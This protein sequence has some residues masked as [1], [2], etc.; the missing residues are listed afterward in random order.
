MITEL[1]SWLTRWL[2]QINWFAEINWNKSEVVVGL[3]SGLTVNSNSYVMLMLFSHSQFLHIFPPKAA[4]S[5]FRMTLKVLPG[6]TRSATT[7]WHPSWC[8]HLVT[9]RH[10]LIPMLERN[11]CSSKEHTQMSARRIRVQ[12]LNFFLFFLHLNFIFKHF[13]HKLT[14]IKSQSI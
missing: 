6:G 11:C 10:F 12:E 3:Q 9:T 14:R 7:E 8:A 2:S 4:S 5:P 1:L 13:V